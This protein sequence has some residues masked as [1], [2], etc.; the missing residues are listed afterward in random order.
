MG[1]VDIIDRV[2][3]MDKV[4]RKKSGLDGQGGINR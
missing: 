4:D 3:W 2:D 1:K